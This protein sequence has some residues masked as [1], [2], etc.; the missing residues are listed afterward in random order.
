[1]DKPKWAPKSSPRNRTKHSFSGHILLI[2]FFGMLFAAAPRPPIIAHN[3]E[4]HSK[5]IGFIDVS[6]PPLGPTSGA[7]RHIKNFKKLKKRA[8]RCMR[9]LRPQNN[10]PHAAWERFL[11]SHVPFLAFFIRPQKRA[12]TFIFKRFLRFF[13]PPDAHA[14]MCIWSPKARLALRFKARKGSFGTK[15]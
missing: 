14:Q 8:L 11:H 7:P 9:A 12:E 5:S 1:M 15:Y 2:S 6:T 13:H 3:F 4:I 10:E